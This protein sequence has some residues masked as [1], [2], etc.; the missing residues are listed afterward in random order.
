MHVKALLILALSS[1]AF[2]YPSTNATIEERAS[3]GWVGSF[4]EDDPGCTNPDGQDG[5]NGARPTVGKGQCKSFNPQTGRVGIDWGAG[6]FRFSTLTAY[7]GNGC[8]GDIQ[9]IV[10]NVDNTAGD[11]FMLSNLGCVG[12]YDVGN[13]CFWSSVKAS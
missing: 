9:A 1:G 11:C 6:H 3:R 8:S 10:T 7:V 4:D 13:P 5:T 2:T 12:G